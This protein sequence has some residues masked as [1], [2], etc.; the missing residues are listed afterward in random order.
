MSTVYVMSASIDE[1]GNAHG[2]KAGNQSG[3]E[4]K[5]QSWYLHKK[6]WRVFRAKESAV[7]AKIAKC[8]K[9]AVANK[10]IGYDQ[11]QRNTL[12]KEAEKVG[13]DVSKVTAPCE[14][15]CSAL[16][17]V[18]C[19]YAGITDLP[20]DFRTGNMPSNLLKTGRF[21]ELTGDKYTKQSAY[22]KAGDILV[23]KTKGHTVV[24]VSNGSKAKAD[25][26]EVPKDD[27][28]K[29]WV[30]VTGKSVNVRS[31]PGVGNT[32]LGVVHK[33]DSLSYGGEDRDVDGVTWHLIAYKN[34]NAWI[35]GK[36]S[37]VE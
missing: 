29:R 32:I 15:D 3:R 7:A 11:Y 30:K 8:V 1:N 4:L 10:K 5:K 6:G 33:G 34:Q 24:V 28:I 37:E 13:F 25:E 26:V 17:R 18:C 35:S 23:T 36:Y 16:V 9:A 2:G 19:A 31:A 12:Y 27:G 21:I 14:T 20:S 22:L